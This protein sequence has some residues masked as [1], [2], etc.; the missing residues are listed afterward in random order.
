MMKKKVNIDEANNAVTQPLVSIVMAVYNGERHLRE[1][2]QSILDQSYPSLELFIADDGSTDRSQKILEEFAE[3]DS[4]IR[5]RKNI[6]NL[7]VVRNFLTALEMTQGEFIC[8]SDQDDFWEK[9]KLKVLV[10]L[11]EKDRRNMLACSDLAICDEELRITYPSFWKAT[12]V[13][14]PRGDVGELAFLRNLAPGCSMMFRREVRDCLLK[15]KDGGPFMHDH[16]AFVVGTALG[17]V[18]FTKE[19]LVRYRQHAANQIGAFYDSTINKERIIRELSEKVEFIR[20]ASLDHARFRLERLMAFCECFQ[21]GGLLKRLSFL[22]YYLFLRN[23]YLMD[24]MLGVLACL[25]PG[26]YTGLKKMGKKETT[27]ILLKRIFFIGWTILVLSFFIG[28]YVA[29]K[30][31]RFLSWH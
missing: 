4:R 11:I 26:V 16:L 27:G 19:K 10:A 13:C 9:D 20:N 14:P 24:Q 22:K 23:H 28:Q 17:H 3:K 21:N 2:I 5:V 18:V 1:Q 31:E 12:G 8:F 29:P 7:G 25:S 6:K 15:L 30:I